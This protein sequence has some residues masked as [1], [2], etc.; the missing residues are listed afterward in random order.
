MI[1]E[2][3]TVAC[4]N[5][6]LP[7]M[8]LLAGLANVELV[9]LRQLRSPESITDPNRYS[10]PFGYKLGRG[11]GWFVNGLVFSA[12]VFLPKAMVIYW[13]TSSMHQFLTHLIVMHPRVRKRFGIWLRPHEGERP[14]RML[15]LQFRSRYRLLR[16][17]YAKRP[18]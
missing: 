12:A 11:F 2:G 5:A 1:T 3:L 17:I 4:T 10:D 14:Y 15:F 16:Y 13:C 9:Y 8:V 7:V 6:V 18:E